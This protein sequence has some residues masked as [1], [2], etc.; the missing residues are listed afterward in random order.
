MLTL[1][2]IFAARVL[3]CHQQS[4]SQT[5]F[6]GVLERP[7]ADS[8]VRAVEQWTSELK[9]LLS[10]GESNF[11]NILHRRTMLQLEHHNNAQ[12]SQARRKRNRV[13]FPLFFCLRLQLHP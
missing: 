4:E 11:I 7:P 3:S 6:V 10:E 1:S 5:Q 8:R 12:L 13:R 9:E 2:V